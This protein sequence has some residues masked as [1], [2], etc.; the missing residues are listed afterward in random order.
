VPT[1]IPP[2]S[3]ATLEGISQVIGEAYTGSAIDGLVSAAGLPT[4]DVSTKWRRLHDI[5]T[6]EQKRTHSG[7]RVI[8]LLRQ[9]VNPR[10]FAPNPAGFEEIRASV[11]RYLAFEGLMVREDGQVQRITPAQTLSEA[12]NV[13][14]RLHDE[15]VRRSVHAQVFKYCTK[16]LIA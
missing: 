6:R 4:S 9:A 3:D 11:H 12:D 2:L 5:L 15:L 14:R 13:A 1:K 8:A 7:V 10:R 16:E